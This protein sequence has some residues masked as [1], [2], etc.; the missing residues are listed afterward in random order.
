MK[1][2]E[3]REEVQDMIVEDITLFNNEVDDLIYKIAQGNEYDEDG[4]IIIRKGVSR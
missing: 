1:F 4:D 3:L 2:C